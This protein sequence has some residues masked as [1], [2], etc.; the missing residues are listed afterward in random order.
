LYG[1]KIWTHLSSSQFTRLTDRQTDGQTD[2][3]FIARP[4]LHS[5]QRGNKSAST[6]QRQSICL[7]R[8]YNGLMAV[9]LMVIPSL[10]KWSWPRCDLDLDLWPL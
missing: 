6:P 8:T 3:F 9:K 10:E 1:I 5:M 2:S 4:R 7:R